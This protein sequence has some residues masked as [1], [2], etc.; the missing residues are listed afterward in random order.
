L[1]FPRDDDPEILDFLYRI[2]CP[3][4]RIYDRENRYRDQYQAWE[5]K[6]LLEVIP[7]NA[8]DYR[9]IESQILEDA[10]TFKLVDLNIDRL[11]QG[12][13]VGVDL[14]EQK[15]KIFPM[16]MGTVSFAAPMVEFE[17]RLLIQKI[18][19]GGHPIARFAINNMSVIT[20]KGGNKKPDKASSQGKIDPVVTMVMALDR[21]MRHIKK[22]S[23]YSTRGVITI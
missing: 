21:A 4:D 22:K 20:D 10:K 23:I 12:H 3:K 2:W 1:A 15:I 17:R 14:E 6:G 11:F 16:G 5:K 7:G 19:H 8:I 9:I 18:N 13:Q